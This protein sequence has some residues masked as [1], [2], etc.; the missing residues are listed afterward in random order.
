M[1]E[2]LFGVIWTLFTAFITFVSYS[3]TSGNI[4][5]NDELVSQAEF[6]EMLGPKIF[7]GIFWAIGLFMIY[8]GLKRMIRDSQTKEFGEICY[9][10]IIDVY[11]SPTVDEDDIPRLG[12]KLFLYIPSLN[13]TKIISQA[14]GYA[15]MSTPYKVGRYAEVKYYN[16]DINLDKVL[17]VED[18]PFE[19]QSV[20]NEFKSYAE[21][22]RERI[23]YNG[24]EYIRKDLVDKKE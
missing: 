7:L 18:I 14:I 11:Q 15:G 22:A 9:G 24:V 2:I 23:M 12:V 13:E 17:E 8:W 6:N 4:Y 3:G 10:K 19:V 5:V 16:G 20:L 21:Q 1:F